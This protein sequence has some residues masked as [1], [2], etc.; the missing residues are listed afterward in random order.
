MSTTSILTINVVSLV[1]LE[2]STQSGEV[3]AS[4]RE[5]DRSKVDDL[6]GSPMSVDSIL[7]PFRPILSESLRFRRL[8]RGS[9]HLRPASLPLFSPSENLGASILIWRFKDIVYF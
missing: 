1:G 6:R 9:L 5:E 8:S 3:E 2:E 4:R 7:A